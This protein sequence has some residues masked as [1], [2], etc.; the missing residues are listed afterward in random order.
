[1]NELY[2]WVSQQP[3]GLRTFKTFQQKLENLSRA[4]PEQRGLYR[5]LSNLVGGYIETFD[6]EPLP[7]GVADRRPSSP[8]GA[9]G[10]SGSASK[11]GSPP[12][13]HKSCCVI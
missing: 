7:V 12:C 6:E 1:M 8:A 13:R 3:H 2:R 11:L 5:L 9:V 4:E 10:K